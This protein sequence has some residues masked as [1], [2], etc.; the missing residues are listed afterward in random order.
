MGF[1]SSIGNAFKSLG[2]KIGQ[3]ASYLGKKT[4]QGLD[5]GIQGLKKGTDFLDKY[6]FGLDHFIP[7]YTAFK[8]I[9]RFKR[10]N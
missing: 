6:S 10:W 8:R 7:Y 2:H 4:L 5:Y 9:R 1:F 3:G